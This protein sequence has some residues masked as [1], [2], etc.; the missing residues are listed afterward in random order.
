[1]DGIVSLYDSLNGTYLTKMY[2]NNDWTRYIDKREKELVKQIFDQYSSGNIKTQ[3]IL[4]LGMGPGRWS[5]F[6]LEQGYG[7]VYGYDISPKMID[8][9]KKIIKNSNFSATV[10]DIQKLSFNKN[11]FDKVFCFRAFKYVDNPNRSLKEIGR[12]LKPEG[13]ILIEF[14]NKSCLSMLAKLASSILNTLRRSKLKEDSYRWYFSKT[15]FYNLH[16][17]ES[18]FTLNNLEI[19][20]KKIVSILPAIPLPTL[21]GRLTKC[22]IICDDIL[23]ALLP[24]YFFAR[25]I[26]IL[27][28][29]K[30]NE[31]PKYKK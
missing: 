7:H 2:L 11:S 25:S 17:I 5:R 10:G 29:K 28:K 19:L 22:W 3:K 26:L 9:A 6:F 1:M 23:K 12:V 13:S 24:S 20:D 15:H 8:F 21:D 16:E 31:I 18:L 14:A 4:D 27:A 30:A